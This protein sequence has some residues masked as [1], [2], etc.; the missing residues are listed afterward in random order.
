MSPIALARRLARSVQPLLRRHERLQVAALCTRDGPDGVPEVL[1]V[2]SRGSG[3]WI[4]PK[5]WPMAGRSL[6]QAAAR[7]AWEEAGVRGRVEHTPIGSFAAEKLTGGGLALPCRITVFRLHCSAQADGF[8]EAGQRTLRWLP[9]QD[10]AG[11]VREP[12]LRALLAAL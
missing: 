2:T 10:A 7:E 1:L 9:P 5:G 8:P 11:M 4:L 6:A 12:E 3:R